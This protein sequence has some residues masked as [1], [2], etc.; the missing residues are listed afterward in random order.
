MYADCI[1]KRVPISIIILWLYVCVFICLWISMNTFQS[2]LQRL[3]IHIHK[4]VWIKIDAYAKLSALYLRLRACTYMSEFA[5][6]F[7]QASVCTCLCVC[8]CVCEQTGIIA[9][10]HK[11]IMASLTLRLKMHRNTL[12]RYTPTRLLCNAIQNLRRIITDTL[13]QILSKTEHAHTHIHT[14]TQTHAITKS[15][16]PGCRHNEI[17]TH[18]SLWYK[19]KNCR[20][21]RMQK[22]FLLNLRFSGSFQWVKQGFKRQFKVDTPK[23]KPRFWPECIMCLW[24]DT[25]YSDKTF[26]FPPSCDVVIHILVHSL[27]LRFRR[28]QIMW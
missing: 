16:L 5:H 14:H 22:Y 13:W 6:M 19:R 7:L 18:K 4:C 10:H 17:I 20:Y 9:D 3:Y 25:R 12:T 15:H 24:A 26:T 21:Q 1:G 11:T 23:N 27:C 8:L 28:R 2:V